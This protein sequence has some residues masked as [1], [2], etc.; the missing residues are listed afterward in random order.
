MSVW[1]PCLRSAPTGGPSQKRARMGART[2]SPLPEPTGAGSLPRRGCAA[3]PAPAADGRGGVRGALKQARDVAGA[4]SGHE[5]HRDPTSGSPS[6][7]GVPRSLTRSRMPA[8]S[9]EVTPGSSLADVRLSTHSDATPPRRRA[10]SP[11]VRSHRPLSRS[12]RHVGRR[13]ARRARS[14]WRCRSDGV[15]RR[16]RILRARRRSCSLVWVVM[17]LPPP[18]AR[19]SRGTRRTHIS[20]MKAEL[21]SPKGRS[22]LPLRFASRALQAFSAKTW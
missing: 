17:A 19:P 2:A 15:A 1:I 11:R 12:R 20:R 16:R 9:L 7:G 14:L 13:G 22:V 10:S 21:S 8:V 3:S 6:P 18:T 4:L 5:E